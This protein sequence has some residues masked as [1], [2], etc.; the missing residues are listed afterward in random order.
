MS[1]TYIMFL[2]CSFHSQL[3]SLKGDTLPEGSVLGSPLL[4][5]FEGFILS[6]YINILSLVEYYLDGLEP[7]DHLT[8]VEGVGIL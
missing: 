1:Y 5:T 3:A 2:F 4:K 8:L 7:T 6:V